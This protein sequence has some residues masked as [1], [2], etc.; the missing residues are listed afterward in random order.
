MLG[1]VSA[2]AGC[3]IRKVPCYALPA[4]VARMLLCSLRDSA[5]TAGPKRGIYSALSLPRDPWF[6]S[7]PGC[8]SNLDFL[9]P[10][11]KT[12]AKSGNWGPGP[13]SGVNFE[14]G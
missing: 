4:M 14:T 6:Q 10:A 3:T 7:H 5:E 2:F 8:P 11:P 13:V 1:G 9:G 12:S